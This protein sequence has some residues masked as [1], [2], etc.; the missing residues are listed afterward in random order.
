[1]SFIE[2]ILLHLYITRLKPTGSDIINEWSTSQNWPRSLRYCGEELLGASA[3]LRDKNSKLYQSHRLDR[4]RTM[5]HPWKAVQ[6]SPQF[7]TV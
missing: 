3:L 2:F 6:T 4:S 5:T 7:T 1:M